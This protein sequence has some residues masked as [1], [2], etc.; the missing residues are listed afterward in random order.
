MSKMKSHS[1]LNK[2]V[3]KRAGKT[4]KITQAG[5]QHNTGKKSAKHNRQTR[6]LSLISKAD[7]KRLKTMLKK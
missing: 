2:R 3:K 5:Y 4:V 1:G 7:M 6:K